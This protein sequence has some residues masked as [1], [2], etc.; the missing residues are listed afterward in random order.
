MTQQPNP[1]RQRFEEMRM[2]EPPWRG[3]RAAEEQIVR[4][5]AWDEGYRAALTRSEVS[6]KEIGDT[7]MESG[8]ELSVRAVVAIHALQLQRPRWVSVEEIR[9]AIGDWVLDD[10]TKNMRMPM[11]VVQKALAK[12]LH[13][14]LHLQR[15]PLKR[16]NMV[17]GAT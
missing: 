10:S 2:T 14:A 12:Y 8:G 1:Y 11:I 7:A 16:E 17:K 5:Q 9:V 4:A 15:P 13:H 6:L 3:S